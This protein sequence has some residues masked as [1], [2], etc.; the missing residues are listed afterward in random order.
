MTKVSGKSFLTATVPELPGSGGDGGSRELGADPIPCDS[1]HPP[2]RAGEVRRAAPGRGVR[3][4]R[5]GLALG[6]A[7]LAWAGEDR[8]GHPPPQK[9][10][11]RLTSLSQGARPA[12]GWGWGWGTS[13]TPAAGKGESWAPPGILPPGPR[14]PRAGRADARGA[15][16]SFPLAGPP[17]PVLRQGPRERGR[18]PAPRRPPR[19]GALRPPAPTPARHL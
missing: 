10:P 3:V 1:G 15:P 8:R 11:A 2:T 7:C 14:A 4:S 5:L 12:A 6:S 16:P 18:C 9:Q 17:G 19:A 13:R